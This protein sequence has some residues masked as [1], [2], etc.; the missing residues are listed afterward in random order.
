MISTP[1]GSV[2]PDWVVWAVVSVTEHS[3]KTQKFEFD[4]YIALFGRSDSP[5]D[6][7]PST[8]SPVTDG[9]AMV[10]PTA[11]AT[12]SCPITDGATQADTAV[13]E[14]PAST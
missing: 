7:V 10:D 12:A 8:A 13:A 3:W 5:A 2:S 6:K 4:E 1:V 9:V 11:A 14:N